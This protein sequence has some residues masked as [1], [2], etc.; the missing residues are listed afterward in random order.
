MRG[1]VVV[2]DACVLV[3]IRLATTLLWLAEAGLFHPLWSETI[4]DEV[5]RNLPKVR[6][7]PEPAK[8]RV[9]MMREAFGAEALVDGFHELIDEMPCDPKDRHVLAAAVRG[10]AD[11]I[12]TF[13]LKDFPNEAAATYGIEIVHPDSFLLELLGEDADAIVAVLER[14]TAAFR[15]PPTSVTQF[16]A[17]LTVTVPMFANL[18]ADAF[19]DPIGTPSKVPALVGASQEDALVAIGTPGDLANPAAV[20][21]AWWSGLLHDL[22]LAR[23]LTFHP[24]AWGDY[25]WAIDHLRDRSLAFKVI[26]AVDAPDEIAFMR[27]VPEVAAT[28][29]VF[30]SYLTSMTFLTL[31]ELGDGTWRVWG[32]GPRILSAADV[33]PSR[34]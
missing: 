28:A 16:L 17:S 15:N 10:G 13:N 25:Q 34:G 12:V 8:R 3:P 30:E 27:F 32:L 19:S 20:A 2:L 11:A 7:A 31:I 21:F 6:V 22:D 23:E 4:L 14:S 24:P 18:T 1:P 29:Q 26:R 9:S 33:R 5:Q